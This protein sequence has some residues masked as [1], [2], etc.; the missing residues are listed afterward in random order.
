MQIYLR[1]GGWFFIHSFRFPCLFFHR[2]MKSKL[3]K[4]MDRE[5]QENYRFAIKRNVPYDKLIDFIA[6]NQIKRRG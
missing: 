6:E 5:V 3:E 1:Q 2:K 4:I